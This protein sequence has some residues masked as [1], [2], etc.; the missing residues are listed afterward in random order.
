MN[1]YVNEWTNEWSRKWMNDRIVEWVHD[2]VH[3]K[4]VARGL[5]NAFQ[6][7]KTPLIDVCIAV[8][9]AVAGWKQ[10]NV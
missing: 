6:L 4:Y 1:E 8:A 9:V 5:H 2:C 7:D 3:G 10:F